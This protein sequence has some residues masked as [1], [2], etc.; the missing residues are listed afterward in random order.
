MGA[1]IKLRF[2]FRGRITQRCVTRTPPSAHRHTDCLTPLPLPP[3]TP[4]GASVP[5]PLDARAS[6][7]SPSLSSVRARLPPMRAHLLT[8]TLLALAAASVRGVTHEVPVARE[9]RALITVVPD[10]K[11]V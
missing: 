6:I 1:N 3:Q 7:L 11:C 9:A 4:R 5:H 8:A 2:F 10:F